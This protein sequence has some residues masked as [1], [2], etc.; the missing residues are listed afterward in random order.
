LRSS[1]TLQNPVHLEKAIKWLSLASDVNGD[2]GVLIRYSLVRFRNWHPAGWQPSYP[3]ATGY[4][5]PAFLDYSRFVKNGS[6]KVR[7]SKMADWLVS[8]QNPDGS[9]KGGNIE[10]KNGSFAFDTGQI[11]FGQCALALYISFWVCD[12]G[13]FYFCEG[14]GIKVIWKRA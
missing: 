2:G 12:E 11:I 14:I 8:I 9:I 4:I 5:I 1:I 6:Y 10:S 13:V 7:A 3:E